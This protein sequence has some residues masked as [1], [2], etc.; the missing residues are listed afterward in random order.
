[1]PESIKVATFSNEILRRLKTTHMEANQ[2]DCERILIELMD[3]LAAMG[4]TEEWREKVMRAAIIGY[5]RLLERVRKGEIP[6]N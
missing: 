4:Y 3:N 1:M 2:E 6:R 5:M